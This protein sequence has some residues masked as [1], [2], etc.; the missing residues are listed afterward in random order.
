[1]P[2]DTKTIRENYDAQVKDKEY[3]VER[4]KLKAVVKDSNQEK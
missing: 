2:Q 3:Q 4:A 1:M